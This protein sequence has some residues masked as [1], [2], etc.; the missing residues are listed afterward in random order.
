VAYTEITLPLHPD[1]LSI[2]P[3]FYYGVNNSRYF[4]IS[5]A[6]LNFL[7]CHS[8][9]NKLQLLVSKDCACVGFTI[10]GSFVSAF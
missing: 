9:Q 7:Q 4:L 3:T 8:L 10:F 2:S 5:F 6:I 1:T